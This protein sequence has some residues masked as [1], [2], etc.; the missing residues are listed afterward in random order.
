MPPSPPVPGIYRCLMNLGT[1]HFLL[2]ALGH[3]NELVDELQEARHAAHHEEDRENGASSHQ[4]SHLADGGDGGNLVDRIA[5]DHQDTAAGEDGR[6]AHF[7]HQLRR[8]LLVRLMLPDLNVVLRGQD[9]IVDGGT[10]LYTGYHDITDE[11]HGVS[12]QIGEGHVHIGGDQ[13]G[14]HGRRRKQQGVEGNGHHQEHQQHGNHIHIAVVVAHD[15]AHVQGTRRTARDIGL[16]RIVGFQQR[17]DLF[18]ILEGRLALTL[19]LDVDQEPRIA[20]L[21]EELRDA[22]R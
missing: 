19:G 13:D 15:G 7:R 9:R 16:I 4:M 2:H 12:H 8:P 10:E 22:F 1:D 6:E 21:M 5:A 17:L 3:H 11:Q 18:I 20:V 14:D